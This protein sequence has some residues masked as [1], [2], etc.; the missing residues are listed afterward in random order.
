MAE[1]AREPPHEVLGVA[2]DAPD[3]VVEAAARRLTADVH[4]DQPDGDVQE[5][6]RIQKTKAALL[7]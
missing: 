3:T 2:E 1:A 4:P 7:D 6:K 5:F